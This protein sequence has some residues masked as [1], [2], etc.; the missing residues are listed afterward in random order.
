MLKE[1]LIK[2][3][4][5]KIVSILYGLIITSSAL[6]IGSVFNIDQFFENIFFDNYFFGIKLK[7][8]FLFYILDIIIISLIILLIEKD[9]HFGYILTIF[10]ATLNVIENLFD[11]SSF[12]DYPHMVIEELLIILIYFYLVILSYHKNYKTKVYK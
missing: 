4:K 5:D 9:M 10:W 8:Y 3:N 6:L 12:K 1:L 7:L 11:I 2:N